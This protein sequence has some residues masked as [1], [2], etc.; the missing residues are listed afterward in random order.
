MASLTSHGWWTSLEVAGLRPFWTEEN[1][2]YVNYNPG[3]PQL[4]EA[5]TH[6]TRFASIK[7]TDRPT[8]QYSD[9]NIHGNHSLVYEP[10]EEAVLPY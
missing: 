7:L 4:V 1:M 5:S 9:I 6:S 8:L 2:V 3:K 10:A